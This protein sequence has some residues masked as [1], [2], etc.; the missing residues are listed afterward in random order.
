MFD[1]MISIIKKN[2]DYYLYLF[3][4]FFFFGFKTNLSHCHPHTVCGFFKKYFYFEIIVDS[5]E[6]A[7][8][9]RSCVPLTQLAPHFT[10]LK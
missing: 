7:K 1:L 8:D 10:Y 4:F 2:K 9:Q 6:I 5:Q 3:F